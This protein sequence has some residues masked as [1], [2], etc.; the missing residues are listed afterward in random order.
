[1]SM[2]HDVMIGELGNVVSIIE[3]YFLINLTV[4]VLIANAS[5]WQK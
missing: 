2:I 4:S 5:G 3:N 1:M